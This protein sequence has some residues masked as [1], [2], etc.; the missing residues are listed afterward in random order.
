MCTE[1]MTRTAV[2]P[3]RTGTGRD[4]ESGAERETGTGTITANPLGTAGGAVATGA[5]TIARTITLTRYEQRPSL[6]A[7][8]TVNLFCLF[9]FRYMDYWSPSCPVLS[10]SKMLDK[11][12]RLILR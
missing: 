9:P 7:T 4:P 5:E 1:T 3:V 8:A 11:I 6:V 10:D 12:F 2:L